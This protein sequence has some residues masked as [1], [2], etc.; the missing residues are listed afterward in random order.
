MVA[1]VLVRHLQHLQGEGAVQRG[2]GKAPA[3]EDLLQGRVGEGIG[4]AA[5]VLGARAEDGRLLGADRSQ[6]G[7]LFNKETA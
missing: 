4:D 3:G 6:V 5:Q 2:G 7:C 1:G